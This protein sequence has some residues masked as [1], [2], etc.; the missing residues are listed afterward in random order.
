MLFCVAATLSYRIGLVFKVYF[1]IEFCDE[2]IEYR[3][4]YIAHGKLFLGILTNLCHPCTTCADIVFA[5][6]GQVAIAQFVESIVVE[7][8]TIGPGPLVL[9]LV[10]VDIDKAV[11]N[12]FDTFNVAILD[13]INK[14]F[15][16]ADGQEK[17]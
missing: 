8:E 13:I 9:A 14:S 17:A 1:V 10:V 15:L 3:L 7:N 12:L 16:F 6:A 2:I 4:F 11:E 5:D